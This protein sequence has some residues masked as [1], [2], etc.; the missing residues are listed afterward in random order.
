[1]PGK[2]TVPAVAPALPH[3]PGNVI[4]MVENE[5]GFPYPLIDHTKCIRCGICLR[6]CPAE[7]EDDEKIQAVLAG[8][9]RNPDIQRAS[10]SGGIFTHLAEAV[11]KKNGIVF[12]VTMEGDRATTREIE[13][14]GDIP[15]LRGSK[16]VQSCT[17]KAYRHVVRYL[18]E[19]RWVLF[20]GTPC[21]I[22]GVAQC[23]KKRLQPPYYR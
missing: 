3:A 1:M 23:F 21:Q 10:S 2:E 15:G 9:S 20:S 5:E 16:Y 14:V 13:N 19:G 11:L 22:A 8:Y 6:N 12:G 7:P 17:E 4:Q 18:E